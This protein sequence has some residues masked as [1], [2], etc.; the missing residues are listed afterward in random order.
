M[1]P[2]P[3]PPR[4]ADG[5]AWMAFYIAAMGDIA[6][7]LHR[8]SGRPSTDLVLKFLEH[9]PAISDAM[10][11]QGNWD[12]PDCLYHDRLLTPGGTDIPVTVRSIVNMI[13][14]LAAAIIDEQIL[15]QSITLGKGFA[16]LLR[17]YGFDD[18]D[19]LRQLGIML[20]EPGHESLL[21]SVAGIDRLEKQFARLF[22]EDEFLS[23]Y[24]LRALST[25]HRD[26]PHKLDFDGVG[27]TISYRPVRRPGRGPSPDRVRLRRPGRPGHGPE[28]RRLP[29]HDELHSG[30]D[31]CARRLQQRRVRQTVHDQDGA[32]GQRSGCPDRVRPHRLG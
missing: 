26:H 10:E 31:Q 30:P 12:A 19:K 5:T 8:S 4:H 13:P 15:I 20:A 21:L 1:P 23:R 3:D 24:G 7:A 28:G 32:R 6:A 22:D 9:Y 29:G 2:G 11:A 17:R 27:A 25:Y 16:G 14:M 18:R